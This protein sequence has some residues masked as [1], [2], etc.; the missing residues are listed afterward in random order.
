MD[1]SVPAK[2][3]TV[4]PSDARHL[5][6]TCHFD[7]QR[8]IS[9]GNVKRLEV[10]MVNDRFVPGTM[11][12]FAVLPDESR[13]ILNGNHTL[14]AIAA[15]GTSQVMVFVFKPVAD[16]AEA[17][18]LYGS[19]DIH[20]ARSWVDALR[21]RGIDKNIVLPTKVMPAV[22]L[23]MQG[24]QYAPKN[25]E[26]NKSREPRFEVMEDYKEA[27]AML[28][29]AIS[30]SPRTHQ[31][32]VF[33]MG[34]MAVAL[35]SMRYQPS[36]AM[37]FWQGLAHDDGLSLGDPRKTL[38]R[39]LL[40][41][42]IIGSKASHVMSRA[43]IHAWNAYFDGHRLQTCRPSLTTDVVFKG[44]PWGTRKG[45]DEAPKRQVKPVADDEQ[46]HLSDLF[47]TG[48]QVT[49]N[50]SRPVVYFKQGQAG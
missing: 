34:V 1:K 48:M 18:K 25:I 31:Q 43:A 5:R 3:V 21:A 11:V 7:R 46:G 4:T 33:R 17:A 10:E 45:A 36:L 37:E 28:Q 49:E 9:E 2:V 6:E 27:A 12:Y 26:A 8:H 47:E 14:E 13:L 20:K 41:T 24:F 30:G 40:N 35:E 23:I 15:S 16:E 29:A 44:T 19:F 38:L 32:A 42:R 22:G 39:F 50:G